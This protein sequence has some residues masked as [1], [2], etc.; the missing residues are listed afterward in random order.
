MTHFNDRRR[1]KFLISDLF[2]T[3]GG[4]L[5][6]HVLD[7]SRPSDYNHS[8][9]APWYIFMT[10]MGKHARRRSSPRREQLSWQSSP[11]VATF[12]INIYPSPILSQL[13]L[14]ATSINSISK[15]KLN[16]Q[17]FTTPQCVL[18]FLS[19]SSF[20]QQ[21]KIKENVFTFVFFE[22]MITCFRWNG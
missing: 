11:K 2:A 21:T 22:I 8:H 18:L 13:L 10:V 4:F 7:N 16:L 14:Y 19:P 5:G 12:R 20:W 17:S 3:G 1:W 15:G 6:F 9:F